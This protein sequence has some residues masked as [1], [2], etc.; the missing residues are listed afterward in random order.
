[1]LMKIISEMKDYIKVFIL[2]QIGS[3]L[4]EYQKSY[5][6]LKTSKLLLLVLPI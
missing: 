2:M 3:K 4:D 5:Q 6:D 1:M